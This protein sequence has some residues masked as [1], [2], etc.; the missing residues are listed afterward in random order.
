MPITPNLT[1]GILAASIFA[2]ILLIGLI[3]VLIQHLRNR[4]LTR[5]LEANRGL[6]EAEARAAMTMR[7]KR[8]AVVPQTMLMRVS[9]DGSLGAIGEFVDVELGE[10]IQRGGK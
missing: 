1:I 5:D 8:D 4:R 7:A 2:F 9:S 6:P 3:G 10:E